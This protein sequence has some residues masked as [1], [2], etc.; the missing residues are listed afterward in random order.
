[1][2]HPIKLYGCRL[3]GHSH[4][5]E[6]FLSLLGLSAQAQIVWTGPELDGF[7]GA[8]RLLRLTIQ[9]G[10][11]RP[12]ALA[13]EWGP[14]EVSPHLAATGSW[15]PPEPTQRPL[16]DGLRLLTIV[17]VERE[18]ELVTSFWLA[19]DDGRPLPAPVAGQFLPIAV[20]L[21]VHGVLRRTY[22][23]SGYATGCYRLSIKRERLPGKLLGLVSNFVH[24]RWQ[25][26]S[27]VSSGAPQGDFVLDPA[28]SRPIVMLAGGIGITPILAML[29]ALA[30]DDPTRRTVL[31]TGAR[32]EADHPFRGEI[33]GL[34]EVMPNLT[35]H[36]RYSEAAGANADSFG[37][38]DDVL[39]AAL[40]PESEVDAYL[41]GPA[42]FMSAM[43]TGLAALG[44][45]EARIRFEAFGPAT[46]ERRSRDASRD[47]GAQSDVPPIVTFA[48]SGLTAAFDARAFNLLEFAEDL[49]LTPPFGCR[50]G[51]C[52]SCLAR[53]IS[54]AVRYPEPP[55]AAPGDD[56]V[57]LCC[58]LPDGDVTIDA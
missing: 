53:R 25:V 6:L 35:T 12:H 31:I 30:A 11:F 18:T 40:L 24:D 42:P 29:R 44:V 57:L 47:P 55:K 13:Q 37:Y 34:R 36:T 21:P 10:V 58:A 45:P 38:I 7:Y 41:C 52:G 23:I 3:S 19:A 9:N 54:G 1:M 14:A 46:L 20:D 28:S 26:G 48:R 33:A 16:L 51:S 22:T 32:N 15:K 50:S 4:R 17:Q 39:L 49:G 8:E 56:E 43:D 27:R 5:G 2:A